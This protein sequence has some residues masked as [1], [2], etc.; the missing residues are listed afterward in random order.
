LLFRNWGSTSVFGGTHMHKKCGL[1]LI[2][3]Y[4]IMF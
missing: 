2:K 3:Y 4:K 1:Y